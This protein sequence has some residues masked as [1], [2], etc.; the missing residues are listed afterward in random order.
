MH[1]NEGRS[2]DRQAAEDSGIADRSVLPGGSL[3]HTA[4]RYSQAFALARQQRA[5]YGL[6][7]DGAVLR[8]L[9]HGDD[10]PVD[11]V[12]DRMLPNHSLSRQSL[13]QLA[14]LVAQPLGAARV[15]LATLLQF[16]GLLL[17]L[18]SQILFS[19]VQ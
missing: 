5:Q 12:P 13:C 7:A 10:S 6:G 11:V 8:P 4:D 18:R 16:C 15:G 19:H 1:R 2:A 3:F 17:H 9:G 14:R